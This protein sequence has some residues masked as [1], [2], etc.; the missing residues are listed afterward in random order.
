MKIVQSQYKIKYNK[1]L[2][3][4]SITLFDTDI[5]IV[6]KDVKLLFGGYKVWEGK[7]NS[8]GKVSFKLKM[9]DDIVRVAHT[10]L[11]LKV[12]KKKYRLAE[13]RSVVDD[14]PHIAYR[15]EYNNQI[16]AIRSTADNDNMFFSK[17]P[18]YNIPKRE[19]DKYVNGLGKTNRDPKYVVFFEKKTMQ[20]AESAYQLFS[21]YAKDEAAYRFVL[22]KEAVEYEDIK[23]LYGEQ[24]VTKGSREYFEVLHNAKLL[25]SSETPAHLVSDRNVEYELMRLINDVPYIF[26]QHGIMFLKSIESPT[27][28][29]FWKENAKPTQLKTVV[30]SDLEMEE[31]YKVGYKEEDLLKSGLAIFDN[32]DRSKVKNKI[33]YMPTYR[34]WEEYGVLNGN[35]K[36]TSY[37]LDILEIDEMF[38]DLGLSE[39]LVIIPHPKFKD[40]ANEI[41]DVISSTIISS[42][43]Q[44]RDEVKLMITDISSIA[45][46]AQF[47]GAY[48]IY[49][50]KR[51][52]E[53]EQHLKMKTPCNELNTNGVITKDYE[54]LKQA[55]LEAID[56]AYV[57]DQFYV[58]N[59]KKLCEFDDGNNCNRIK[60]YIDTVVK[61]D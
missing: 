47:R 57:M 26:L 5:N 56:K 61:G 24:V 29:G 23:R 36:E 54:Q 7:A 30:S 53:Y 51:L 50:W 13:K 9:S 46:D 40:L 25:V 38:K 8:K 22:D 37:Y 17:I 32:I 11:F 49:D 39:E 4:L 12:G 18:S 16:V 27:M 45:H 35:Y 14:Y 3:R 41:N 59:F 44:V 43:N 31:F 20:A 33:V 52:S 15:F 60:T 28:S 55:V 2:N 1:F 58:D 10:T 21:K 42:Y 34:T 19:I 48:L 6:N